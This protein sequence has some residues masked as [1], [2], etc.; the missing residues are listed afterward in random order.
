M[1]E[2][3]SM[4]I[5]TQESRKLKAMVTVKSKYPPRKF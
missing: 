1:K 4:D 2:V 5:Q 3:K